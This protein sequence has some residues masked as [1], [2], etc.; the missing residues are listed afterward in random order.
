LFFCKD[1][2]SIHSHKTGK[3]AYL[4]L[5]ACNIEK[6]KQTGTLLI[7]IA[8]LF[9]GLNGCNINTGK[10]L[11]VMVVAGGHSFDTTEFVE[12]FSAMDEI[13]F[14]T[15]MQPRANRMIAAG[16]TGQYD[17]IVFYDMWSEADSAVRAGY[18]RLLEKGIGMV[19]LH[20]ALAGYQQWVE[21]ANIIGGK[22]HTPESYADSS[23]HS[24]FQ[25]DIEMDV[26]V[27]R[28]DHPVTRGMQDFSILDEGYSNIEVKSDVMVLLTTDHPASSAE[29]GWVTTYRNSKLVYLMPGHDKQAYV[30]PNYRKLIANSIEFVYRQGQF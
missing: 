11:N 9:M 10:Q 18:Q 27:V 15:V 24:G 22:Y 29:I 17:V 6:M 21:Y 2:F 23:M 28:K 19:F 12:M 16:E 26:T 13:T 3:N 5:F 14:D 4:V 7:S 25:H 8:I 30:N 20:H 1:S